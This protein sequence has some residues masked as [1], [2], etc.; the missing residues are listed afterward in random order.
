[1]CECGDALRATSGEAEMAEVAKGA[2][3]APQATACAADKSSDDCRREEWLNHML[4][5]R[6]MCSY[7]RGM[8][9]TNGDATASFSYR[10]DTQNLEFLALH[11]LITHCRSSF[12]RTG[13]WGSSQA[14]ARPTPF[15][16]HLVQQGASGHRQSLRAAARPHRH[17]SCPVHTDTAA[18]CPRQ[19]CFNCYDGGRSGPPRHQ[20][21]RFQPAAQYNAKGHNAKGYNPSLQ[22]PP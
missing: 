5:Q 22:H 20:R 2:L 8:Y 4:C 11:T 1:M 14:A 15:A 6:A 7:G 17:G 16:A 10:G 19:L 12:V 9:T 3:F 13:R 21:L 18:A